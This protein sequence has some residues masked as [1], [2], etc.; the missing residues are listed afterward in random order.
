MVE[1]TELLS[2][3]FKVRYHTV[4]CPQVLQKHIISKPNEAIT[5]NNSS[6]RKRD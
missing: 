1:E 6:F 4:S 2:M 3:C 5:R